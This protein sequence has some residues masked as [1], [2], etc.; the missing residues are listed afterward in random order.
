MVRLIAKISPWF[1]PIPSAYFVARSSIA[2]LDVPIEIAIIIGAVLE[3]LGIATVH[4]ALSLYRW[5]IKPAV[6]RE[7]GAWEKAPLLLSI[8][9]CGVYFMAVI[10]LS[11]VLE[12]APGMSAIA[13]VIFPF[14]AIVGALTLGIVYQHDERVAK[15]GRKDTGMLGINAVYYAITA[16]IVHRING[17]GLADIPALPAPQGQDANENA[18]DTSIILPVCELCGH[19]VTDGNMGSHRRWHCPALKEQEATKNDSRE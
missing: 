9:T 10:F 19:T 17:K 3:L 18:N 11:V 7:K 12:T 4:T 16:R 14:V 8:I 13:P 5:N 15:Y 6:S 2:H 1:A